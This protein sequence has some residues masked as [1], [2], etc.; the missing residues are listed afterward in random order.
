ML[1]KESPLR[2]FPWEEI[3]DTSAKNVLLLYVVLKYRKEKRLVKSSY[4]MLTSAQSL[5]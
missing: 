2:D 5:N 1:R 3:S 4:N